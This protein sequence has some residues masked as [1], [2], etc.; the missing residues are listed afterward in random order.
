MPMHKEMIDKGYLHGIEVVNGN[1]YSAEA[2]QIAIDNHLG[3]IG[4]SDV[5]NLIDWDY[6]PHTGG[7]RPVTLV[8]ASAKNSKAVKD[9]LMDRRTVIWFKNNLFGLE[10]SL[11]PL[12]EASLSIESAVYNNE[13]QIMGLTIKNNSDAIF[14]LKNNSDYTFSNSDDMVQVPAQGSKYLQVKTL[15]R[16]NQLILDFTVMNALVAPKQY[17]QITLKRRID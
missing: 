11:N 3:I 1:G 15:K 4:T 12:L 6:K 8:F 17:A 10:R 2:F 9:A 7:H 16:L 13:T 14:L 5:H